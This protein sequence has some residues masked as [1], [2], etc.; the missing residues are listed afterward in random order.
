MFTGRLIQKVRTN[1]GLANAA[2]E[3]FGISKQMENHPAGFFWTFGG[4][5]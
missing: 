1:H 4:D 3:H 5:L 2:V